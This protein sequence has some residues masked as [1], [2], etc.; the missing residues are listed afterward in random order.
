[1]ST[2]VTTEGIGKTPTRRLSFWVE[3]VVL[4]LALSLDS[5]LLAQDQSP[6]R[7][8][9]LFIAMDDLNDWIG[10]MGGHPQ[11]KTP[12][13]DRL[14][15]SGM[16]FT[17]AHCAAPAC[18]PSRTA[19]FTGMAPNVSGVYINSQKM[20]EVLPD[21]EIIPK[22]FSRHGY[23]ASG[24][25]KML[26]Y[27][28]DARSWDEYFPEASTERPIP[29]TLYPENR[30]VSLP[31]GGPWQY[32]ETD[33][34]GLE[35]TDEEFGGDYTVSE[36]VSGELAKKHE[37]PFFL[38]CG[39]YRPHE[40]WFVPEKYFEPF[41]LESI[42]LPPGYQEDDL[43]DLPPEGQRLGATRYFA[44]IQQ[45]GE[46]KHAIQS[47]LASI[48][49]ADT[50]L[51]RVLDA[52]DRS[53]YAD[54]TIVV[55]WSDHGWHLGEKQHWQKYTA[56][57]RC[58]RVPLIV[59]VPPAAPGLPNG[60]TSA[61]CDQPVNLVS[62]YPTLLELCGLPASKVHDGPSL[63]PLLQNPNADWPHVSV[64]Y[65]Q[66]PGGYGLS[67]QTWRY[68]HYA[69]GDE[70][71]YDI[72]ADPFEWTNLAAD[73][74]YAQQLAQLRA[75]GPTE[76][77]PLRPPSVASLGS[78]TWS[79]IEETAAPASRPDGSSFPVHFINRTE[80]PVKL[81]WVDRTG[82]PKFFRNIAP[83]QTAQQQTRPGAIWQIS[84]EAEQPLGYFQVGDRSAKAIVPAS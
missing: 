1:M 3:A 72:E 78:L 28:I 74:K 58:T 2:Q 14:A 40:P 50:M 38:A 82:K 31:R 49:F 9:V 27:F 65:L 17:N 43:N 7:P 81:Y 59:R 32:I 21:A 44:H 36:W 68:I 63:I 30:P 83:G 33:W 35:A 62:L 4:V 18:N 26:H 23:R 71:L 75:K 19:I 8:N 47:Y 54:N 70:E 20:R 13:L 11:A 84:S 46:W 56:W 52:L 77:A 61:V 57:R 6:P 25:G 15:K 66:R 37:K 29:R 53:A 48:Y 73:P 42:E 34:G 41:P 79:P 10:C 16:L 39:I 22:T 80:S 5:H 60:T 67:D 76:F 64:T 45:H 12:N 24:S 69:N 51:G 55:L